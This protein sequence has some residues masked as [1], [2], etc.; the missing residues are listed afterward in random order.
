MISITIILHPHYHDYHLQPHHHRTVLIN[1][2]IL[3]II[4]S[5]NIISNIIIII[6]VVIITAIIAPTRLVA[7]SPRTYS[8]HS[9]MLRSV[10]NQW[11]LAPLRLGHRDRTAS[12]SGSKRHLP[13]LPAVPPGAAGA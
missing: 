9:R 4:I 10:H 13:D 8:Q 5:T 3:T 1:T 12:C 7:S 6:V 2:I 11:L